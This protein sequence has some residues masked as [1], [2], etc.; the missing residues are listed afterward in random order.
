MSEFNVKTLFTTVKLTNG[1]VGV[2]LPGLSERHFKLDIPVAEFCLIMAY[3]Q[4]G[5]PPA[6]TRIA[7]FAKFAAACAAI[8]AAHLPLLVTDDAELVFLRALAPRTFLRRESETMVRKLYQKNESVYTSGYTSGYA[9]GTEAP[10]V[11]TPLA[12]CDDPPADTASG[13]TSPLAG[14]DDPPADAP[15]ASPAKVDVPAQYQLLMGTGPDALSPARIEEMTKLIGNYRIGELLTQLPERVVPMGDGEL[16]REYPYPVVGAPVKFGAAVYPSYKSASCAI[17][18]LQAV[19][20]NF[21]WAA[22]SC[23]QFVLAGGGPLKH[24]R[25]DSDR[26]ADS[27]YDFFLLADTDEQARAAIADFHRWVAAH[28][29]G[30]FMAWRSAHA[31]TYTTADTVYQVVLRLNPSVERVLINFDLDF[32]CVAFDGK[33][34]W[35]IPRGLAAL[36]SGLHVCDPARQS[37]TFNRRVSK[38]SR[39]NYRFAVPGLTHETHQRLHTSIGKTPGIAAVAA[40]D[41]LCRSAVEKMMRSLCK[42]GCGRNDSDYAPAPN[43]IGPD[44]TPEGLCRYV[45]EQAELVCTG[46]LPHIEVFTSALA[47]LL[48]APAGGGL[49]SSAAARAA[50]DADFAYVPAGAPP[51]PISFLRRLGHGQLSGSI[52]PVTMSSWFPDE[53]EE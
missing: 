37:T 22:R 42:R 15:H 6:R 29:G 25:V 43:M 53:S 9:S 45:R 27:D 12:G 34:L 24:L 46:A 20:P 7:D 4:T 40:Y 32:C 30:H 28:S 31:V 33:R 10:L 23:L 50:G 8:G 52:H 51:T 17:A 47:A 35:T 41:D 3:H 16:E 13:A 21:P 5:C 2:Q 36:S 48:D 49:A 38:Y 11:V 1:E 18:E 44:R 19:L 39:R 14:C 26:F